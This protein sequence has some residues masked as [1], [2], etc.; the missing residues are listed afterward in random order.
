MEQYCS[1]AQG[2]ALSPDFLVH[3]NLTA[4]EATQELEAVLSGADGHEIV[5][6]VMAIS[7][8]AAEVA[9]EELLDALKAIRRSAVDH[10]F[11]EAGENA[12]QIKHT[13]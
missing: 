9:Q 6:A 4:S 13:S 11:A 1:D 8:S 3:G 2:R 7:S 10:R 12:L 5:R